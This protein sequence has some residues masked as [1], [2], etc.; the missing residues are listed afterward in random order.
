MASLRAVDIRI[1]R[2]VTSTQN[3]DLGLDRFIRHFKM[4]ETVFIVIGA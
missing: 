3:F 1:R 2:A 4:N